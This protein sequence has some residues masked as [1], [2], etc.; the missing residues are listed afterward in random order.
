MVIGSKKSSCEVEAERW[1]VSRNRGIKE[2]AVGIY[3]YWYRGIAKVPRYRRGGQDES[4][5]Y[6]CSL[7][8]TNRQYAMGQFLSDELSRSKVYRKLGVEKTDGTG[9][10]QVTSFISLPAFFTL[11]TELGR[12]ARKKAQMGLSSVP[13]PSSL[14]LG[15]LTRLFRLLSQATGG[16]K[17]IFHHCRASRVIGLEGHFFLWGREIDT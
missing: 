14:P 16:E 13:T 15:N 17:K 12:W 7:Y 1:K 11:R 8:L 6:H 5:V 3:P 10:M 2:I 4:A 9:E